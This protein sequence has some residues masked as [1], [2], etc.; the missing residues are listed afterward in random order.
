MISW[1]RFTKSWQTSYGDETTAL[2][3]RAHRRIILVAAGVLLVIAVAIRVLNNHFLTGDGELESEWFVYLYDNGFGGLATIKSNYGMM[4]L[5]LLWVTTKLGLG[6][7]TS[8]KLITYGFEVL[9][10]ALVFFIL[11]DKGRST[12]ASLLLAAC[13]W[14]V[15]TVILNGPIWGQCDVILVVF[16]LA[17]WWAIVKNRQVVAWVLFG[18]GLAFKIQAVFFL[19]FLALWYYRANWNFPDQPSRLLV[20]RLSPLAA[21]VTLFLC[22]TPGLIAGRG[23]GNTLSSY[24]AFFAPTTGNT[25]AIYGGGIANV[26]QLVGRGNGPVLGVAITAVLFTFVLTLLLLLAALVRVKSG[27]FEDIHL[28]PVVLMVLIPYFLPYMHERYF[29]GAELFAAIFAFITRNRVLAATAVLLQ[30]TSFPGYAQVLFEPDRASLSITP[31]M[32]S[33]VNAAILT[34]LGY[35]LLRRTVPTTIVTAVE[36]ES[37]KAIEGT[38]EA[39]RIRHRLVDS[40]VGYQNMHLRKRHKPLVQTVKS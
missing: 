6:P 18:I 37:R 30:I 19:P 26:W 9:L 11:K 13:T 23:F 35:R 7:I 17:S 8:V 21:V 20:K 32:M 12:H 25:Q 5:T 34:V 24:F 3:S 33:L 31:A 4:F 22:Q 38:P 36:E 39:P 27:S 16:C 1:E 15:P 29:F 10:A 40:G 28:L 2:D 14:F